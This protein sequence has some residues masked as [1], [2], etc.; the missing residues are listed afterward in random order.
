MQKM[1]I[2]KISIGDQIY[3][4]DFQTSITLYIYCKMKRFSCH[5]KIIYLPVSGFF[6]FVL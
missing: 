1:F 6:C 2:L 4:V 5:K 3:Y